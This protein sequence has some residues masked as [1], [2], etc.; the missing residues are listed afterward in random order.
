[1]GRRPMHTPEEI[2]A[3]LHGVH[4]GWRGHHDYDLT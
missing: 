3:K 2:V 4:R 1:M